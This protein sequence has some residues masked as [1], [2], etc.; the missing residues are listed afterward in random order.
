MEAK[1][2]AH[3]A[4]QR[5]RDELGGPPAQLPTWPLIVYETR[6]KSLSNGNYEI[7]YCSPPDGVKLP[8]LSDITPVNTKV[9]GP[10]W[11]Q[12]CMEISK[13]DLKKV[14]ERMG[15]SEEDGMFVDN[16]MYNQY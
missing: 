4:F 11:N 7:H 6:E 2:R 5:R 14:E 16:H 9:T 12:G 3:Q 10:H 13:A 8:I 1:L 15:S